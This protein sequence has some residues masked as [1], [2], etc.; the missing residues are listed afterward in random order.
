MFLSEVLFSDL[1]TF[2]FFLTIQLLELYISVPKTLPEKHRCTIK[3]F[4][5]WGQG[6]YG[7]G[8]T[9]KDASSGM[10]RGG[11]HSGTFPKYLELGGG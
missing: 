5:V 10:I 7:E 6:W 3:I 2:I 11:G 4:M 9:V 1:M 8:V